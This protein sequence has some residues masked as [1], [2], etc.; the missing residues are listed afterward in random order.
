MTVAKFSG[1]LHTEDGPKPVKYAVISAGAGDNSIVA[2]VTGKKI[3]VIQYTLTCDTAD[4]TYRFESGAGGTAL[5][6]VI[7]MADNG[8]VSAMCEQGLF[9]TA[10]GAALSLEATAGAFYGHCA[11]VETI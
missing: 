11:Y 6:G 9:E 2:A 4:A 8:A 7:P 5:T 10:A 1:K 3:R